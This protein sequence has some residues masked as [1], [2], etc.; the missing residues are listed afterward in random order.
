[1]L[2][3]LLQRLR[4]WAQGLFKKTAT[5]PAAPSLSSM[6]IIFK[7]DPPTLAYLN[8]LLDVQEGLDQKKLDVLTSRLRASNVKLATEVDTLSHDTA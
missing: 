1:M 5:S 6:D 4:L 3:A 8:R 7:I 2:V